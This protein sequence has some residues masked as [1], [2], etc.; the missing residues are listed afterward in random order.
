VSA[1]LGID[2]LTRRLAECPQEFLAEPRLAG[3]EGGVHVAAVVADLLEDLG[4]L[5]PLTDAEAA[6]W[7][8]GRAQ[9]RNRLRLTLVA[10]WLCRDARLLAARRHAAA[11]RRWL[12]S[13]L[14][15]MAELVAADLFVSDP[16]RREELARSLCAAL[17]VV[18]EGETAEQASDRLKSLSSV[19]RAK[20]IR[21]TRAQQERARKLREKMEAEKARAAAAR[22]SSE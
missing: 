22:Y 15:G 18:P 2:A 12:A 6:P 10:C 20:V 4:A 8:H 21:E 9:D 13:R 5:E 17:G 19:E 1:A 7:E 11:V 3:Q 14:Q 16:D